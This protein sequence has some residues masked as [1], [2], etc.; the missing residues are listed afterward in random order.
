MTHSAP[1]A[2]PAVELN[3][4]TALRPGP[5]TGPVREAE[6]L[7]GLPSVRPVDA[8]S[9]AGRVRSSRRTVVVLD[10]DPTGSQTVAGVPVLTAW[11]VDDLRWALRQEAPAFYVLTN[12]RSLGPEQAAAR[13]RQVVTALLDAARLEDRRFAIV[14]RGDSTLRGHYPLET[15]VIDD[16]LV[17]RTGRHADG[18]LLCPAY[19]DAGRVTVGDV[20]WMRTDHGML[21][22]A[23]S[24]FA[25]DATFGYHSSDLRGFVEEKTGGRW[26][27]EQV[28]S[29]G[30]EEIRRGGEQRVTELLTTLRGGQPAIVNATCDD[31]LRVVALAALAAEE[32][33][34]RFLYRTGP[35]FVRARAGLSARP[36]LVAAELYEGPPRA[37]HG[38][39]VIGSHV[40]LT[41]RQLD[42]L[43]RRGG[44][45]EIELD[46]ARLLDPALR[47]AHV[48]SV[49]DRATR[50]LDV[51]EVVVRTT[52]RVVTGA[53]AALS[54]AIA[55]HVS[56]AL[57]DVVRAVIETRIPRFVVAKGGITSS[58][59]A[60]EGLGIRRAW[61]RGTLLPGIVSAWSAVDGA[62]PG[63]PYVVFAGNVGDDRSLAQIVDVLREE[64]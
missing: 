4:V 62:A 50:A 30:L 15:D 5:G 63:M 26:R 57:V 6:L 55:R 34:R 38:L 56:A 24:E 31:D 49:A 3:P 29:I 7:A 22:V 37:R 60:T 46:V 28:L 53:D 58:D 51:A 17:R 9:V 48:K 32:Q 39:V 11:S 40:S 16:V 52:R 36:P 44:V 59:V 13:N 19:V 10:D 23:A 2:A 21:P 41:T 18:V 14:S 35:S 61:V 12:T 47:D 33:G 1:I 25:R 42:G 27:A 20:H 64:A 43:R 8:A 45:R 54:L